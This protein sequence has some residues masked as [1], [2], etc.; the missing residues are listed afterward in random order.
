[1]DKTPFL[2]VIAPI[3]NPC[4][5]DD[6]LDEKA[7]KENFYRLLDTGIKGMY[8]NGGTGDAQNLTQAERLKIA[9]FMI[10]ELKKHDKTAIVHV[11]QTTQRE[12]LE[13]TRQAKELGADA[14]ASI[15]PRKPWAQIVQY[16]RALAGEGLP[17]IVYYIPAMTG[18][19]AGVNELRLLMDI[20]GVI[21]IKM[22]D[23]NVFLLHCLRLEYPDRIIYSGCD[24]MLVPGILYGADGCIGTWMNLIPDV[25]VR[26]TEAVMNGQADSIRPLMEAHTQ[27][28][29]LA[30]KYG[31]IDTFEEIMKA[32]GYAGR[33]FRH[34][35]SWDPGK[36]DPD[37]LRQLLELIQKMQA[38]IA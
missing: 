30:G 14:V 36:V 9:A 17:V 1:M 5:E 20:P 13:L 21:G 34:P 16:Y 6:T 35:S 19:T 37:T 7:L 38:L 2:R 8:I 23:F 11:G 26:I 25:Y 32:L 28:L 33:C 27:F 18:I 24:E 12:A 3:V 15:P 22:T 29:A 10:P 31:P 4:F